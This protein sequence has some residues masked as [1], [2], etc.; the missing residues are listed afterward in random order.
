MIPANLNIATLFPAAAIR[1]NRPADPFRDVLIEEKVS[2]Y[3]PVSPNP[4]PCPSQTFEPAGNGVQT[5]RIVNNILR[6]RIIVDIN[7]DAAQGSDFRGELREAR[8][9]LALALVGVRH[10]G[11]LLRKIQVGRRE[12][13]GQQSRVLSLLPSFWEVR[14]PGVDK[15]FRLEDKGALFARGRTGL[16]RL[17]LLEGP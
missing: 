16:C 1:P 8:V 14:D 6:P 3:N 7:C 5:Y 15:Y 11:C 12:F 17:R 10:A 4:T 13:E 9:V 2:D